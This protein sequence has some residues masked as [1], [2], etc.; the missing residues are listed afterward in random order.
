M[1]PTNSAPLPFR[2]CD[3]P[4][5]QWRGYLCETIGK[6]T[7]GTMARMQRLMQHEWVATITAVGTGGGTAAGM[8][9]DAINVGVGIIGG[10]CAIVSTVAAIYFHNKNYKINARRLEDE[11][12]WHELDKIERH[13][14]NP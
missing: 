13:N 5:S 9:M 7:K 3:I 11:R 8:S 10:T 14:E 6:I 1:R 4:P 12:L 2:R